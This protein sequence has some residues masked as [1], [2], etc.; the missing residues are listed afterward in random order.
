MGNKNNKDE[1]N[2]DNWDKIERYAVRTATC[3]LLVSCLSLVLQLGE[4]RWEN[5]QYVA[6]QLAKADNIIVEDYVS[7]VEEYGISEEEDAVYS[8]LG[9]DYVGVGK[10]QVSSNGKYCVYRT[11]AVNWYAEM[12]G[13]VEGSED[14]ELVQSYCDNREYYVEFEKVSAVN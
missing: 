3:L 5:E 13:A 12:V 2:T 11:L 14:W 9:V 6:E 1:K 7:K 8:E 10:L 4:A